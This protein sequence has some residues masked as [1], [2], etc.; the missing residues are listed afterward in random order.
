ML[1]KE[2]SI[3]RAEK[4]GKEAFRMWQKKSGRKMQDRANIPGK[5]ANRIRLKNQI[6]K[7]NGKINIL[8][9]LH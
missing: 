9:I 5:E 1:G 8:C 3:I 7:L 2:N 6:K 4:S